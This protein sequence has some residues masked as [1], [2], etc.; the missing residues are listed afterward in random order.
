MSVEDNLRVINKVG[1]AYNARDWDRVAKLHAESVIGWSPESPEPRKGRAAIREEFVGYATAFPDSRLQVERTFGQG[2]WVCGEFTFTGT[3]KG[4][5]PGPGG[6]TV[7]ATN[8]PLRMT[9]AV[10]FKFDRGEIVERHEYFDLSGMMA[11]LGL[12]PQ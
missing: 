9:Y 6:Q 11:Q 1:E 7:P 5:L 2:D 4:A 8:K 12:A 3:H 10:V